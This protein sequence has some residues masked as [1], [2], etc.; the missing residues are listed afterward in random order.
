MGIY[1]IYLS[2]LRIFQSCIYS[3]HYM[4]KHVIK[5]LTG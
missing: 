1:N 5:C 3:G 2:L 4:G